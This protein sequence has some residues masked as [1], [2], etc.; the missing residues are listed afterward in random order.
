MD[1]LPVLVP[2]PAYG[3]VGLAWIKPQVGQVDQSPPSG[4]RPVAPLPEL[5]GHLGTEVAAGGQVDQ[6]FHLVVH[7]PGPAGYPDNADQ[8][9]GLAAAGFR[10]DD[11]DFA[12]QIQ[13][14]PKP[15][16]SATK[17]QSHSVS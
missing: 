13:N 1:L 12:A 5:V 16:S 14:T 15:A 2:T 8:A 11:G 9:A 3:R 6:D 7:C 10:V 4:R 17:P